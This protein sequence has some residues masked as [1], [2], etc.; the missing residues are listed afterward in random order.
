MTLHTL[1][2]PSRQDP[3]GKAQALT[4]VRFRLTAQA[5]PD[6]PCRVLN[7]L[8]MQYL[9]AE[10]AQWQVSQGQLNLELEVAEVSWHRAQLIAERMRGLVDVAAVTLEEA[11]PL[12]ALA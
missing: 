5:Q 10:Q 11:R 3:W 9:M 8:A 4:R 2:T 6:V 7:L 12:A 1:D